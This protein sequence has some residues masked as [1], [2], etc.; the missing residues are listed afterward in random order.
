MLGTRKPTPARFVIAAHYVTAHAVL[1]VTIVAVSI[2]AAFPFKLH[3]HAF[4]TVNSRSDQLM[5][6]CN[7]KTCPALQS[8]PNAHL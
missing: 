6:H 1:Q 4:D 8:A 2:H 7:K 5:M 3:G